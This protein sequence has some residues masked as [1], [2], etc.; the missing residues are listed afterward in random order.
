[1]GNFQTVRSITDNM[2]AALTQ[3]GLNF[4]KKAYDDERGIPA[5]LMPFGQVFYAGESFE[6][7]FGQRPKY[8]EA[9]FTVKVALNERDADDMIRTQQDWVHRVRG[10]MTVES[11]NSGELLDSKPVTRVSVE[12]ADV[13]NHREMSFLTIRVAVRYR[14]L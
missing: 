4:S 3:T 2:Q 14:E 12:R 8:V 11:M 7:A 5:S 10:T 1:M 13:E 6:Y 9:A